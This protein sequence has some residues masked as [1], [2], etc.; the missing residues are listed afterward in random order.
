VRSE[1]QKEI[2]RKYEASEKG[3]AA[4]RRHEAA[5]VA[6]GGRKKA[7]LARSEKPIS[8]ARIAARRRWSKRNPAY[9]RQDRAMRRTRARMPL[10]KAFQ[11]EI[12]GMYLFCSIFSGFE[13]DHIIPLKHAQVS[14]LHTPAN[15]QILTRTENRRKGNKWKEQR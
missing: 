1:R 7:E 14:G 6:S 15:L 4:K 10:P 8:E 11:A 13:V 3:K 12:D 2:R 5:Y 9:S